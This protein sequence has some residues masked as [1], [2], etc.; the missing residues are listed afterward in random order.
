MA[1][2]CEI[3]P[4]GAIVKSK[5]IPDSGRAEPEVNACRDGQLPLCGPALVGANSTPTVQLAK[6]ASVEGQVY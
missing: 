4:E 3:E 5:P 2:V 6:A 1:T